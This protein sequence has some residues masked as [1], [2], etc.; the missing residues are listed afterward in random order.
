MNCATMLCLILMYYSTASKPASSLAAD[1]EVYYYFPS[2]RLRGSLPFNRRATCYWNPPQDPAHAGG[3][4]PSFCAENQYQMDHGSKEKS[5]YPWHR[6]LPSDNPCQLLS[7]R[8][9]LSQ[10]SD[11]R[12]KIIV[13]R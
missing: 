13:R 1:Y 8:L 3:D 6:P 11:Y 12:R 7:H 10:V 5:G 2:V 9:R 4:H